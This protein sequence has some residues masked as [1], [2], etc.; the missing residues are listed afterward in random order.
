M[1]NITSGAVW[2]LITVFGGLAAVSTWLVKSCA[3][4]SDTGKPYLCQG[5]AWFIGIVGGFLFG[6][7]AL[8]WEVG[9]FTEPL[10]RDAWIVLTLLGLSCL[11]WLVYEQ[12]YA[13]AWAPDDT[14]QRFEMRIWLCVRDGSL[15]V[16]GAAILVSGPAVCTMCGLY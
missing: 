10:C 15:L 6:L 8:F 14:S 7:A 2:S 1:M 5:R 3:D 4:T 12:G 16:L 13:L 11:M 9:G